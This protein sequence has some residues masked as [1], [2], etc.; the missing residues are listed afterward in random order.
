MKRNPYTL[1]FGK[2]PSEIISRMQTENEIIES[3]S[4]TPPSQQIAMI[5]GV[6]GAGKTVFMTN[7]LNQLKKDK[8]WICVE[9]NPEQD[10]LL[11]LAAKLSSNPELSQI[12]YQA[13]IN[14]SFF[15]HWCR[16]QKYTTDYRYRNRSFKNVRKSKEKRKTCFSIH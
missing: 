7:V 10:L 1:L 9:L 6:R 14:L 16:N 8:Q 5:T 13:Q 2:A 3:F 11:G 4:A 15:S 12:F